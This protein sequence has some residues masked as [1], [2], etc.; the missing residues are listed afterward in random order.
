V[1][2]EEPWS[3]DLLSAQIAEEI[4]GVVKTASFTAL[5][6][7]GIVVKRW[8]IQFTIKKKVT[9]VLILL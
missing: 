4:L 1:V 8:K 6:V 5:E 9:F 3:Q 2:I 7:I